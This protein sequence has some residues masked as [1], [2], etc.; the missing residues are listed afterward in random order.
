MC[1]LKS[2]A[3]QKKLL[4]EADLTF[5]GAVKIALSMET[6][7]TN[8]KQMHNDFSAGAQKSTEEVCRIKVQNQKKAH[9]P[10]APQIA[11]KVGSY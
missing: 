9:T 5:G 3:I 7:T 2:E 11:K 8:T 10:Q 4:T 1:G 6:A